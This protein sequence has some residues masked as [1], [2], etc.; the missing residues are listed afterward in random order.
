MAEGTPVDI[1]LNPLGVP[2]RMNIGQILEANLGLISYKLGM[3]FKQILEMY[4]N[5][6]DEELLIRMAIPKLSE[7]YPNIKNYSVNVIIKLLQ[8]LSN[9]V[10]ISCPLFNFSVDKMIKKFD[11]RF[12]L[13]L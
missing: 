7:L 12:S 3:E 11:K 1:V 4:K 2:S 6:K 9:G 13:D 10:K 5:N 8:E